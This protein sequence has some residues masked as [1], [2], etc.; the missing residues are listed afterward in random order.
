MEEN[1][2]DASLIL[3]LSYTKVNIQIISF[4]FK[5]AII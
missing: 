2:I 3:F 1:E 4:I 5:L